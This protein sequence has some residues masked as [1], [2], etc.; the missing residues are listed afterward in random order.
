MKEEKSIKKLVGRIGDTYY[1]CDCIFRYGNIFHGATATVLC[2]VSRENYEYS[3]ETDQLKERFEDLW[4]T[5]VI[6]GGTDQS[7]EDYAQEIFDVDGDEA[8]WDFSGHEYWD[9][10][11]QAVPELAK[12]DYPVFDC[13]RSGRSFSYNMEWDEIYDRELWKCIQEVEEEG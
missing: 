10:I 5:A 1:V 13:V 6:D 11:R 9:M 12:E 3:Q 8:L 4:R 7:L 2:P